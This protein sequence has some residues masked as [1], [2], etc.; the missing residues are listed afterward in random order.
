MPTSISAPLAV[1]GAT[2]NVG[3]GKTTLLRHAKKAECS[4]FLGTPH[5][6]AQRSRSGTGARA[7]AGERT[8]LPFV[9]HTGL[10]GVTPSGDPAIEIITQC[11]ETLEPSDNINLSH[12]YT[13]NHPTKET[14][15]GNLHADL[16]FFFSEANQFPIYF[17]YKNYS[18]YMSSFPQSRRGK[19][20][21]EMKD[22]S[23]QAAI[24]NFK[25]V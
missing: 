19:D 2:L 1:S 21:R 14:I 16:L 12:S 15:R 6:V 5:V 13:L 11:C 10:C 9:A 8:E 25:L 4:P 20:G 7:A 17:L 22:E 3:H 24:S 23:F 18:C